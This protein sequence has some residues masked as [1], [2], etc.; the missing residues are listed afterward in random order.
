MMNHIRISKDLKT[1]RFRNLYLHQIKVFYVYYYPRNNC[2][3][4]NPKP[5]EFLF[6]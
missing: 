4:T 1:V 3:K 2:L 5:E 6:N